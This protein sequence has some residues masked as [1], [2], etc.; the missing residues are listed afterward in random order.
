MFF[1]FFF[2]RNWL[3]DCCNQ[4]SQSVLE[5]RQS[6][7]QDV[8]LKPRSQQMRTN[9]HI[10]K[11]KVILLFLFV[12]CLHS[13]S[14]AFDQEQI[15]SALNNIDGIQYVFPDSSLVLLAEIEQ[16]H[17]EELIARQR[18]RISDM[19]GNIYW[20]KGQ[21]ST[22]ILHYK[23]ALQ[24]AEERKD[25]ASISGLLADIGWVFTDRGQND[26]AIVH[27]TNAIEIA[28]EAELIDE[29]LT[30][31]CYLAHCYDQTGE[32]R[33]AIEIYLPVID[34]YEK[35]GKKS[36]VNDLLMNVGIMYEMLGSLDTAEFYLLRVY[37]SLEPGENPDQMGH[38]KHSLSVFYLNSGE[39]EKANKFAEET[40]TFHR[41][42][43]D[44]YSLCK[45]H[46][47]QGEIH[48]KLNKHQDALKSFRAALSLADELSS[49]PLQIL[50]LKNLSKAYSVKMDFQRAYQT[51][52]K[53]R[54]YVDSLRTQQN[55]NF[56]MDV[57][58]RYRTEQKEKEIDLLNKDK[59]LKAAEIANSQA[60]IRAANFQRM[61]YIGGIV[62]LI[63]FSLFVFRGLQQKK[64]ANHQLKDQ[65]DQIEEKNRE[66]VDSINYAKRIQASILPPIDQFRQEL[67]SFIFYRP[68]D[69]VAGDFYWMEK[70]NDTI[71]FAAADC[72]GHG[73]PGAMVSVVC[74]N[75]LTK[76]R[77]EEN[78]QEP[79][80]IL[81]RTRELV[82]EQFARSG[83]EIKDGMDIALCSL[84]FG[85]D[86]TEAEDRSHAILQY[87]G[88]NNPLW[89]I[90]KGTDQLEEI[91]GTKQP[92]GQY[93]NS[94]PFVNHEVS[95]NEGD[96]IYLFT[97]GYPDQFGGEKGK[98]FKSA[99]LKK[100]LLQIQDSE[101]NDQLAAI[102]QAFE[103]WQGEHEQVDDVCVIG[104][105]V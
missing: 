33:K 59:K 28:Q 50:I 6:P 27:L 54:K 86:S 8:S 76:S 20:H 87:A 70:V 98:K 65:K 63:V 60:E 90:R 2:S 31:E 92:I 17:D 80:K 18:Q 103:N 41:E 75:A 104:V 88:A 14:S 11:I 34:H 58:L 40:I 9:T 19:R 85:K 82:I 57:K 61:F 66:I 64:K 99:N 15:D 93:E 84:T 48:L 4:I 42:I 94:S 45:A 22:S 16:D 77:V 91:K 37:N 25:T 72:T 97:D 55:D 47:I 38:V 105:R 79:A 52:I 1:D 7:V 3:S 95:L 96:S 67:N 68:K 43:G 49:L 74:S 102:K 89:I 39:Y 32:Y 56:L 101:M 44:L 24:I 30:A 23:R 73:V 26:S 62:L 69:I 100:L 36:S 71:C 29:A 46:N 35:E 51:E 21:M 12:C 10:E 13:V 78:I 81:D 53:L 5:E 83:E